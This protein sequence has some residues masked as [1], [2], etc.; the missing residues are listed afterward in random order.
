MLPTIGPRQM[1][2][3]LSENADRVVP[4]TLFTVG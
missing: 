1:V 3:S 4:E 2:Q